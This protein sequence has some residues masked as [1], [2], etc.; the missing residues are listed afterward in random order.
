M[1][2]PR[3][4]KHTAPEVSWSMHRS[5]SSDYAVHTIECDY[6]ASPE[7]AEVNSFGWN[8]MMVF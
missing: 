8:Q 5:L 4:S 7:A 2:R 1:L 3:G 6:H